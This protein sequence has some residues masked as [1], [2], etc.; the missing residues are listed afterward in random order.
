MEA[1]RKLTIPKL[2]QEAISI[3]ANWF[4][5]HAH[6]KI[7]REV[8]SWGYDPQAYLREMTY[9]HVYALFLAIRTRFKH[10]WDSIIDDVAEAILH[11][12]D[13]MVS[14][15]VSKVGL[16]LEFKKRILYH[17]FLWDEKASNYTG[18]PGQAFS[19]SPLYAIAEEACLNAYGPQKGRNTQLLLLFS[20]LFT[21]Y[22][23]IFIDHF[24]TIEIVPGS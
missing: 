21:E 23:G 1:K 10:H 22:L 16:R 8:E 15:M 9:L 17:M 14:D 2:V 20:S 19:D 13:S 18:S 3:L 24:K 12:A 6:G 4:S 7:P 5:A 11:P